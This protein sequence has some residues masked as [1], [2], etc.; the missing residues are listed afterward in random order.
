MLLIDWQEPLFYIVEG[1]RY[2]PTS[3]IQYDGYDPIT[4]GPHE[5]VGMTFAAGYPGGTSWEWGNS[6]WPYSQGGLP[7]GIWE[8][9]TPEGA[10]VMTA[11]VFTM[12]SEPD[13][14]YAQSLPFQAL[15]L[16]G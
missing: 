12:E 10:I 11:L 13:K 8:G 6:R 9:D 4:V 5:S 3:I 1:V 2:G 15:V 7:I 16:S 14:I